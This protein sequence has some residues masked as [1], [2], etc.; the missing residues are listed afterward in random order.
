MVELGR[1]DIYTDTSMISYHLALT[2]R[3]NLEILFNMISY[4]KKHQNSEILFDPT[5]P[6]VDMT[7]FQREDWGLIIN[8]NVKDDMP[9]IVS[10]NESG[11]G[12]MPEPRGQGFTITVYVDCDIGSDCVTRRSRTGFSIF[13][14]GAPIYW[15]SAKKTEL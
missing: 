6:D 5:E 8:G 9:P 11:T 13:F 7:D 4:I 15:R 14:N 2:K 3:G 10:F 12:D 1:V